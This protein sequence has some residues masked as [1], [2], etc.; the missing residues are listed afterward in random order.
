M[1]SY[2][3]QFDCLIS[4]KE[5]KWKDN[6]E[7]VSNVSKLVSV[8]IFFDVNNEFLQALCF[9][10]LSSGACFCSKSWESVVFESKEI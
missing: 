9:F 10:S 3:V 4:I 5:P 6:T 1:I 7:V 8:A 2:T